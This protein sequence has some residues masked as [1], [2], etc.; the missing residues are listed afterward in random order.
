[1]S[2]I[3]PSIVEGKEN[4][5]KVEELLREEYGLIV[6]FNHFSYRDPW[7]VLKD[8]IIKFPTM[9]KREILC[10]IHKHQYKKFKL[11]LAPLAG[12]A[13]INLFPITSPKDKLITNKGA[14][15]EE[16]MNVI[17]EARRDYA[18]YLATAAKYLKTGGVV[19]LAI[20]GGR[21]KS[22]RYKET[23]RPIEHII[24][25]LEEQGINKAS[26]LFVGIGKENETNYRV[27]G[28]DTK[29]K[30]TVKIGPALILAELKEAAK[31][32]NRSID[33][34]AISQLGLIVP[35]PYN[36]LEPTV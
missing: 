19:P 33:K 7:Q 16:R 17:V 22:L 2:T 23:I 10:P 1:M 18:N 15:R 25:A 6:V 13:Q 5:T 9:I 4:L 31:K 30:Y 26:V 11:L 3:T 12:F 8:I 28:F 20:Q 34:E 32:N 27:E 24:T 14:D 35:P 36:K 29:R 21:E